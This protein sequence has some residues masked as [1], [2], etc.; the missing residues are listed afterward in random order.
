MY[1]IVK[2]K[3]VTTRKSHNCVGC[4]RSFPLGTKMLYQFIVDGGD[5]WS[6]YTCSTCQQVID[7]KLSGELSYFEFN[8]GDLREDALQLEQSLKVNNNR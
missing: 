4:C 8:E 2:E 7:E 3:L 6:T 1:E 5:N